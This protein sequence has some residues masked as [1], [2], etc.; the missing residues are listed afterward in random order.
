MSFSVRDAVWDGARYVAVGTSYLPLDG[1]GM[2]AAQ[3]SSDGTTWTDLELPPE[4]FEAGRDLVSVARGDT[5]VVIIGNDVVATSDDRVSWQVRPFDHDVSD[6]EWDGGRFV[7]VGPAGAVTSHDGVS[8]D[9]PIEIWDPPTTVPFNFSPRIACNREVYVAAGP[10]GGLFFSEDAENWSECTVDVDSPVAD[11]VWTG[12]DWVAVTLD[13]RVLVSVDGMTW[14][15]EDVPWEPSPLGTDVSVSNR[16]RL[17]AGGDRV[18]AMADDL[19][20]VRDCVPPSPRRSG[21]RAP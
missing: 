10:D 14:T 17:A 19:L 9:G 13:A 3:V 21:G 11:V 5:R 4:L 2:P 15:V 1:W 6:V 16:F 18:I 8:W 7:T 20:L 12:N